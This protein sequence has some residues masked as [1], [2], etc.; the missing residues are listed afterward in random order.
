MRR[1]NLLRAHG[2][3]TAY[4]YKSADRCRCTAC[5]G[6]N[7]DI[8]RRSKGQ[9]QRRLGS[10]EHDGTNT[11]FYTN[12]GCRCVPCRAAQA[13]YNKS[14]YPQRRAARRAK[15][16]ERRKAQDAYREEH[17][18]EIAEK[19]RCRCEAKRERRRIA[20]RADVGKSR[21]KTR[22]RYAANREKAAAY[23][24]AHRDQLREY[25]RLR[26]RENAGLYKAYDRNRRARLCDAPGTHTDADVLEQYKRQRGK[27][28]W[29]S[30]NPDCAVTL[31]SGYHTDHVIPL[32]LGGANGP[33]NLVLACPACNMQKHANHPMDFAGVMF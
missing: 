22:L 2:S 17:A 6:A 21:E 33:E 31:R 9:Q 16:A 15:A 18:E 4:L 7:V 13:A 29:R 12:H 10:G 25:A 26:Y 30:A 8:C 19:K 28:F 27:C 1:I 3:P 14:Q 20:W 11:S 23:R 24:D 32:I 5:S